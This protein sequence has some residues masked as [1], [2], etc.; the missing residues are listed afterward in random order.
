MLINQS[1]GVRDC[2]PFGRLQRRFCVT[3]TVYSTA[4]LHRLDG[5]AEILY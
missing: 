3:H 5:L 1:A 4:T 2:K